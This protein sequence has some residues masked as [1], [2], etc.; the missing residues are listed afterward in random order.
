MDFPQRFSVEGK[1]SDCQ[2]PLL[3]GGGKSVWIIKVF[4]QKRTII[5]KYKQFSL[6]MEIADTVCNL[7][8]HYREQ[9]KPHWQTG[10][11]PQ[12][13]MHMLGLSME[14]NAHFQELF[15]YHSAENCMIRADLIMESLRKQEMPDQEILREFEAYLA[16]TK[17][18]T[19]SGNRG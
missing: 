11:L 14:L 15:P 16:Q 19:A 10:N 5:K 7:H 8:Q 6:P 13:T 1:S 17:L 3:T 12:A 4:E 18:S 9:V 2:A